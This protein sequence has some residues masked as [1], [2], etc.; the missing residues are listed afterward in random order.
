[1]SSPANIA[2]AELWKVSRQSVRKWFRDERGV[3]RIKGEV[4][5]SLRIPASVAQRV[6]RKLEGLE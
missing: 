3:I 1:M 4:R 5:E 6:H 2:E